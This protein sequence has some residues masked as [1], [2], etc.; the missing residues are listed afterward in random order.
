M[1]I[2]DFGMPLMIL[3]EAMIG[4]TQLANGRNILK[5]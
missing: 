2:N 1:I 5:I 4:F 3:S